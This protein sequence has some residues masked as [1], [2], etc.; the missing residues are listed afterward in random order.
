MKKLSKKL[1]INLGGNL[2]VLAMGFVET[3]TKCL[4][5]VGVFILPLFAISIFYY[6]FTTFSGAHDFESFMTGFIKTFSSHAFIYF[7]P[8]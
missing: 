8:N 4:G 2:G 6:V 5:I 7:I 1:K 3:L